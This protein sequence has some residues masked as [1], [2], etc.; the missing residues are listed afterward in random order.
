MASK[1]KERSSLV[2]SASPVVNLA[3]GQGGSD[4]TRCTE[5]QFSIILDKGKAILT[6]FTD[7]VVA[8]QG[9][10]DTVKKLG[11]TILR[12]ESQ[13]S[14]LKQKRSD[15]VSSSYSENPHNKRQPETDVLQETVNAEVTN[16]AEND[17]LDLL[18][19]NI[20]HDHDESNCPEDEED[21]LRDLDDFYKEESK[22]GTPISPDLA[23]VLNRALPAIAQKKKKIRFGS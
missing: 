20:T 11:D 23:G 21:L 17:D 12:L 5:E 18:F 9:T 4:A 22:V 1:N 8:F 13:I 2:G 7:S 6:R 3:E 15:S 16:D 10:T 19:S 14:S